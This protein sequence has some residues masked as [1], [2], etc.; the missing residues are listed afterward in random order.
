MV[1][2]AHSDTSNSGAAIS[3]G[4]RVTTGDS[5]R[6][7]GDMSWTTGDV[8]SPNPFTNQPGDFTF[9]TGGVAV[10]ADASGFVSGAFTVTLKGDT[11]GGTDTMTGNN[12]TLSASHTGLSN[13]DGGHINLNCGNTFGFT[14]REGGSVNIVCGRDN[15]GTLGSRGGGVY[16]QTGGSSA[17]EP[18]HLAV[19]PEDGTFTDSAVKTWAGAIGS[20]SVLAGGSNSTIATIQTNHNVNERV[21]IYSVQVAGANGSGGFVGIEFSAMAYRTGGTLSVVHV[22]G[23]V[24]TMNTDNKLSSGAGFGD[25]LIFQLTPSGNTVLLQVNSG[26]GAHTGNFIYNIRKQYGGASS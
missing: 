7:T 16:I 1:T 13:Q 10:G 8:T 23:S 12:I 9:T 18:G 3:G 24:A 21:E 25:D 5:Y 11:S 14:V 20:L 19:A 4:F 22:G 26:G 2:G 17:G 6:F 15:N